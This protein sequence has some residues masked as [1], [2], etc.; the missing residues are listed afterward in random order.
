MCFSHFSSV[1]YSTRKSS[2][3]FSCLTSTFR[4]SGG[5]VLGHAPPRVGDTLSILSNQNTPADSGRRLFFIEHEKNLVAH[6][7]IACNFPVVLVL[8]S[9]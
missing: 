1:F 7:G 5:E 2:V 6:I 8:Q 4:C 3:V 9:V